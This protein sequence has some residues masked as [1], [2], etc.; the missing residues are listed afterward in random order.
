MQ[1]LHKFNKRA[2]TVTRDVEHY[3]LDVIISVGYRVKSA[4]GTRFR[5]WATRLLREHLVKGHTLNQKRLAERGL[6]EARQSLELLARTLRNQAL[7]DDTGRAVL[8]LIVGYAD[9]WRLLLEYDENRLAPPSGSSPAR[10]VLPRDLAGADLAR[11]LGRIGY[12]VTR[13]TGSHMRL[14]I[15]VPTG[16]STASSRRA[17]Y[18]KWAKRSA[19]CG[20]FDASNSQSQTHWLPSSFLTI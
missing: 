4:Q 7:V 2:T 5:Q 12:R 17:T 8:D 15:D 6:S 19:L 16:A 3:N 1:N 11:A 9:T 14:T 10:G 13:Q 20:Q 18:A